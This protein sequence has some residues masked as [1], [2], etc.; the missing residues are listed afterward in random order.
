[1]IQ[2]LLSVNTCHGGIA[3]ESLHQWI[4]HNLHIA[5][6]KCK[7]SVAMPACSALHDMLVVPSRSDNYCTLITRQHL[8]AKACT[9]VCSTLSCSKAFCLHG[10]GCCCMAHRAQ[11]KRCWLRP[12]LRSATPHFSTS[13]PPPSSA[14]GVGTRKNLSG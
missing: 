8:G 14:S 6:M 7:M 12:W 9:C 4:L 11:G 10:K 2:L 13:Q 3:F 5:A 1:M